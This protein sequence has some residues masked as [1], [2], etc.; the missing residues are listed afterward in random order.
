MKRCMRC[1]WVL[2]LAGTLVSCGGGGGGGGGPSATPPSAPQPPPP[3]P[4]TTP[5]P[6][7]PPPPPPAATPG[8]FEESDVR[9]T[10]SPGDWIPADSKFGWSGG[11]AGRLTGEKPPGQITA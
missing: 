1:V 10:L 9:V 2:L 3:T 6:P 7:P 5:P 4:T 8:R 11:A